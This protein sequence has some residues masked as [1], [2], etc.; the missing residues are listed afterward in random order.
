MLSVQHRSL[1]MN[2]VVLDAYEN[3]LSNIFLWVLVAD[4]SAANWNELTV[5]TTLKYVREQ[6]PYWN[7]SNGRDHLW[8]FT[9]DHG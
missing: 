8:I 9:H 7:Q 1:P 5:E 4:S 2:T 3:C 6:F